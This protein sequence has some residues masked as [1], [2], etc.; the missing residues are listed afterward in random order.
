LRSSDAFAVSVDTGN[1]RTMQNYHWMDTRLQRA[2]G[3]QFKHSLNGEILVFSYPHPSEHL[4]HTLWCPPLRIVAVNTQTEE[5]KVVFDQVVKPWRFVNLPV[6]NL[7]LEMDPSTEYT[8]V[9]QRILSTSQKRPRIPDNLLVGGTDSSISIHLMIYQLFADSLCDLR[10][11]KETCLTQDGTINYEKLKK[12]Y[13]PWDRGQIYA[14]AGVVLDYSTDYKWSLPRSVIPLSRDVLRCEQEYADEILAAMSGA[15]PSW[16]LAL[17]AVCIGCSRGG[18]WR[19]VL[20]IPPDMPPEVSWR[21]LRPENHIPLC[22]YCARRYDVHRKPQIRL[23]LVRAFWGAR[24]S[25]LELWYDGARGFN[26]GLP[27]DWNKGTDPL[28]PDTF[29]GDTWETG[30]GASEHTFPAWPKD[31]QR[32]QE[33][34]EY[35]KRVADWDVIA[36]DKASSVPSK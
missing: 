13:A 2:I 22:K 32:T 11:V 17:R 9:L 18:T 28:W 10:R 36:H 14:S 7:V 3:A 4:F 21:L 30:S 31:V 16:R 26:G 29:G 1:E 24:F 27:K 20:P 33:Q 8:E 6:G 5:S 35:L 25:A 23:D 19:S 12:R 34:I 15:E